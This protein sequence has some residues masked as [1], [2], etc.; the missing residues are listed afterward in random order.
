MASQLF[1]NNAATTLSGSL[2]QGGT[3]LVVSTGTGAL[4]PAPTG[5]DFA[6]ITL[7]EI[8]EAGNEERIEVAQVTAR[9][10][11]TLTIVR[12]YESMTGQAGGYAY[13]SAGGKT[14]YIELR[15][16]AAGAGNYL[17]KSD[18]LASLTSAATARTNLGLAIGTDVQAYDATLSAVAGVTTGADKVPY[19]TGTDT[20]T[21]ATLTTFG[22]S[23]IDDANAAAARTTL[24]VD[25]AGTAVA[26]AIALG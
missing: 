19:F 16:T 6:L 13:P 24:D 18:N 21:T 1:V 10:A 26:L 4:F 12:D 11:D 3:T 9:T 25:Q 20:A 8:D 15:W 2:T 7:Y 14:V 23:L 17:Q 22:R 5:G